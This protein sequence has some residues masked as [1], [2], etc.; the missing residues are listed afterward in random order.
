MVSNRQ[1]Q[2]DINAIMGASGSGKTSYV[3][4]ELKRRKA[5]RLLIW[6][7]KGEFAREGYG[8]EVTKLSEVIKIMRAAGSRGGFK[9]CYRPRGDDKELKKQFDLFCYAAF[10][11]KNLVLVAEELSDVTT[12]SYAVAGWRK[13]T[14]QGRTEGVT[15]FGLSQNPA[16]IDKAFFGNCSKVRTGRLNFDSHIKTMANCMSASQDE[17]RQ[18][19]IGQFIERDMNTGIV[20]RGKLF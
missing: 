2:A 17:I 12:A 10:H 13:V 16:M 4:S 8:Q 6:D 14:T 3:M 9:I 7:T 18:L 19:L 1:A 15:I 5:K 20:T 11:A